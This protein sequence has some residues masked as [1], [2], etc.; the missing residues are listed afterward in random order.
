MKHRSQ[1]S[2]QAP[3]PFADLAQACAARGRI[4]RLHARGVLLAIGE[5][6]LAADEL[7][8]TALVDRLRAIVA[9]RETDWLAAVRDE[10]LM[11]AT[12][13]V[14]SVDPRFLARPDYD[15]TYTVDAREALEARLRAA[16]ALSIEVEPALL[17]RL[18]AADRLLE[19]LLRS[20][21]P[22]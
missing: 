8:A 14:R 22:G 4:D 19:P 16:E 21:P 9:A 10:I 11:A 1:N 13:H 2:S 12:E 7:G 20:R 3:E 6:I 18:A 17:E 15:L 5:R